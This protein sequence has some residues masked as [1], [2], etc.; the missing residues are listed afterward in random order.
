MML[1]KTY[2]YKM[3]HDGESNLAPQTEEDITEV[4][5]VDPENLAEITNNTY[6][7]IVDVLKAD[8]LS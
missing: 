5:W 1:K 2:W 8:E 6:P 4:K 3:Y 7:S